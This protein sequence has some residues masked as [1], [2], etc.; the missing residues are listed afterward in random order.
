MEN[1]SLAN[2]LR[3]LINDG[4]TLSMALR[5]FADACGWSEDRRQ[6]VSRETNR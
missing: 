4:L 5:V 3:R 1:K 6:R 2:R